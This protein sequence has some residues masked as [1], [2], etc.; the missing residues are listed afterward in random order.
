[1]TNEPRTFAYG[2]N[3]HWE[4]SCPASVAGL[5]PGSA[6]AENVEAEHFHGQ[7]AFGNIASQYD[8]YAGITMFE[9]EGYDTDDL[10]DPIQNAL[11][12]ANVSVGVVDESVARECWMKAID[13][14]SDTPAGDAGR[15]VAYR[16]GWID[17][18]PLQK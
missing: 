11:F 4:C 5:E 1:M 17:E 15:L 13:A 9:S 6:E 10:S 14:Q 2:R 7:N 16:L 18:N 3:E 12:D 8:T